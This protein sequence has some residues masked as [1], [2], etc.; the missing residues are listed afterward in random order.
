MKAKLSHNI[1]IIMLLIITAVTL[2]VLPLKYIKQETIYVYTQ[3]N[4]ISSQESAFIESLRKNRYKVFVNNYKQLKADDVSIWF[5]DINSIKNIK[6]KIPQKYCF[7]YDENYYPIQ[8]EELEEY[9]IVLTP[10]KDL[11]E[12]YT[13][14]NIRSALFYLGENLKDFSF[15]N[16]NNRKDITYYEIK[17]RD[18]YL[19]EFV[20]KN[21]K[22]TLLNKNNIPVSASENNIN[23]L[24]NKT[25]QQSLITIV[26]NIPNNKLIPREIIQATLSGSLV[27]TP[28]NETVYNIYKDNILYF[29]SIHEIEYIIINYSKKQSEVTSKTIKA[30]QISLKEFSSDAS[31]KRFIELLNWLKLNN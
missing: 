30:N 24:Y 4:N 7:I 25:L 2:C 22:I 10:Y 15:N 5:S 6:N 3:T 21:D 8:L 29:T 27:L 12:H 16:I 17:N 14:S 9:P 19:S 26:D 31:A 20:K 28:Y 13:R 11:Y 1:S 23:K 18:S